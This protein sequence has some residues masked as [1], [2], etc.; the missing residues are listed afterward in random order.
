MRALEARPLR[1][2]Q[3]TAAAVAEGLAMR[4]AFHATAEDG[5][6]TLGDGRACRSLV[7]LGNAGP[8]MWRRFSSARDPARDRLDDWSTD[9]VSKLADAL[10]ARALFPFQRPHL[11]FQRWAQKAEPC[12]PSPIGILIHPEYGLWHGYRGAL[13]FADPLQLPPPSKAASPCQTCAD[14]PC[15]STCPVRAFADG[16]YDV[17]ACAGHLARPEG[18]DCMAEGCR[19]RRAC[20][21]GRAFRYVP[22]QAS[23]HMRHFFAVHGPEAP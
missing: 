19:A 22:T 14:R 18:A 17:P 1:L 7:L 4:G 11:P 21:A 3:V 5:V 8:K 13:A 16:A 2:S 20:P 6:P 12:V 15:L 23:F 9:V 10:G